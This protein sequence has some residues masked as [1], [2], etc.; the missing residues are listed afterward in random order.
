MLFRSGLQNITMGVG[1]IWTPTNL[2]N[3]KNIY[4]LEPDE[5]FGVY[6]ISYTRY[7]NDTSHIRIVT[8]QKNNHSFKYA[9]SYKT[10]LDFG[11]IGI[12]V[13]KSN[14]T[15]MFG[16]EVEANL[17]N[18]GIEVR[19]EGAFIQNRLNGLNEDEDF[20]QGILGGDYGFENGVNLAVEMFYSQKE[21]S[22]QDIALNSKSEIL[23]N[24]VSSKFYTGFNISYSFN[25][26]LDEIGRAHV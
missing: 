26:F 22:L 9:F 10:A 17:G 5:V 14:E 8:S 13:I 19:S 16:Y 25:I 6:A 11:E 7:L 21:F 12:N 1:R 23:S 4:A 18:T 2:F 24:L 15:R 20:F 3:H